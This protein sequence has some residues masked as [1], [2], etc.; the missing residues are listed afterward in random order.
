MYI[1]TYEFKIMIV[2]NLDRWTK[3][4]NK[5]L[6]ISKMLYSHVSLCDK[7]ILKMPILLVFGN[8]QFRS[9]NNGWLLL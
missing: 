1:H 9:E 6:V 3:F 2:R 4:N 7:S 5:C 8:S